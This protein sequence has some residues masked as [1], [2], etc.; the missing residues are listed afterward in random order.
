MP[1]SMMRHRR[2]ESHY[3]HGSNRRLGLLLEVG[4]VSLRRRNAGYIQYPLS[5]KAEVPVM[6]TTI[7]TKTVSPPATGMTDDLWPSPHLS[8]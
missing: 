6:G 8:F 4:C 3:H 2:H 5:A 1:V 7:G